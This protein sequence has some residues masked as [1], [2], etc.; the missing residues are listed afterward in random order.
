LEQEIYEALAYAGLRCRSCMRISNIR[1]P[2]IDRIAYHIVHGR[3]AVKARR[4]EDATT[5]RQLF[6]LCRRLPDA[7]APV[8]FCHERVIIETW[9]EGEPLPDIPDCRYLQEAGNLLGDLHAR[10]ELA[11]RPLDRNYSTTGYRA[12]AITALRQMERA[13]ALTSEESRR[14]TKRMDE[15]AP[16]H[17]AGGLTH[18]DF[19]GENMVIDHCGRLRVVDN[20]R[21]GL[22]ALG[23]DLART[24][25]RWA[26]PELQWQSFLRSYATHSAF[27]ELDDSLLFWKIVAVSRAA[28]LRMRVYP[29]QAHIPIACLRM[30]AFDELLR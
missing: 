21:V 24:W 22:N 27:S 8:L 10:T 3:G 1:A 26:L 13:G 6:E 4:L 7:F 18:F 2:E 20:E 16:H 12:S 17:T 28:A 9:I 15:H 11:G 5:A 14:L 29:E 23:L 30:L 19:C 25:Y